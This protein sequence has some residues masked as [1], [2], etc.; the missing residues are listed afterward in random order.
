MGHCYRTH[1]E[2]CGYRS[3]NHLCATGSIFPFREHPAFYRPTSHNPIRSKIVAVTSYVSFA[4]AILSIFLTLPR[5]S[6]I[7]LRVNRFLIRPRILQLS[8]IH[9]Q[10]HSLCIL[11]ACIFSTLQSTCLPPKS[12]LFA[13]LCHLHTNYRFFFSRRVLFQ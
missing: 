2:P 9:A 8:V 13:Q 5:F 3:S 12:C 4:L 6:F 11:H 7:R 1:G 10:V